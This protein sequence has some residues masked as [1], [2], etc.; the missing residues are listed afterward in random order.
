MKRTT[1]LAATALIA[2]SVSAGAETSS[3]GR[4]TVESEY[5]PIEENL[6][7]IN[8]RVVYTDITS[9]DMS[10]PLLHAT[11]VCT[12]AILL[13]AGTISGGGYCHYTDA[14]S[15][16]VVISWAAD[17][18]NAEGRTLGAWNVVGGTGPWASASGGGRFDAG[19]DAEGAYTNNIIGDFMMN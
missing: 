18:L 3:I 9:E 6:L 10:N 4:G 8:A 1:L 19:T 12:G 5:V 17:S 14:A 16:Q 11:G 7:L 13:N 15:E 2:M